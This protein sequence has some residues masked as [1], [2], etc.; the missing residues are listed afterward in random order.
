MK[1]DTDVCHVSVHC[2]EAFQGQSGQRSEVEVIART[3]ALFQWRHTVRR[4]V[5]RR[6]SRVDHIGYNFIYLFI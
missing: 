6:G 5:C 1:L 4:T 2:L 3:N